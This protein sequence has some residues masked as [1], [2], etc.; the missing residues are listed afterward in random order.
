[1]FRHTLRSRMS[2]DKSRKGVRREGGGDNKARL[3]R[4]G[5]VSRPDR[6]I[7]E[8]SHS[9]S[10]ESERENT[11]SR[12]GWK[13]REEPECDAVAAIRRNFGKAKLM[14]QQRASNLAP[15]SSSKKEGSQ[16]QRHV[17]EEKTETPPDISKTAFPNR[18]TKAVLDKLDQKVERALMNDKTLLKMATPRSHSRAK[19]RVDPAAAEEKLGTRYAS[20]QYREGVPSLAHY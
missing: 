18:A 12:A 6:T 17:R 14:L 20:P 15:V 1:M 10:G 4:A 16:Q 2:P 19:A 9:E 8:S 3:Q 13:S 5:L 7:E 11:S